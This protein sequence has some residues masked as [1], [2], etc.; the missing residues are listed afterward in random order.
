MT[1][2][3]DSE[4]GTDQEKSPFQKAA[5]AVVKI[6]RQALELLKEQVDDQGWSMSGHGRRSMKK[7]E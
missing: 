6:N 3:K 2:A 5:Q 7:T 4:Q 1:D